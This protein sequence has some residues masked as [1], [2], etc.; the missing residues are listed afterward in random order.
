M[1]LIHVFSM[2]VLCRENIKVMSQFLAYTSGCPG[3][4]GLVEWEMEPEFCCIF[5]PLGSARITQESKSG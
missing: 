5:L 4:G 2:D 1:S 3:L